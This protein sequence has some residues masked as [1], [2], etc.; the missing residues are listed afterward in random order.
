[1]VV[2]GRISTRPANAASC[3]DLDPTLRRA[4]MRIEF[5]G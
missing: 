2:S 4:V 5:G 3:E 1:V